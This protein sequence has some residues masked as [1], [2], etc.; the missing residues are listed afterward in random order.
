MTTYYV[1]AYASNSIG[2]AYGDQVSFT[3]LGL[4]KQGGGVTDVEGKQYPTII[5]NG[6]EWMKKNLAVKKYRNGDA[7][8]EAIP[9]DSWKN[10]VTGAY[11]DV[12]FNSKLGPNNE[13]GLLYNW[14]AVS[15]SRGLC[16]TGFHVSTDGDWTKLTDFL[17]GL[18]N[19]SGAAIALK[20]TGTDYWPAPN[21]FSTN[22]SGFTG[23]PGGFR[24]NTFG[25]YYYV[26]NHA[27]WWTSSDEQ[28]IP[29]DAFNRTLYS[30]LSVGDRSRTNKSVG[31]SVR[32]VKD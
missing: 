10:R 12:G 14:Y 27:Y 17:G 8:E 20:A 15:D 13:Y 30:N 28:S 6:Q 4:Y 16:P 11:V 1:R 32:C 29:N 9:A 22:Q 21:S 19:T 5:I 18:D 25:N 23:I 26:D 2:A 7:M 24:D 3:T 31:M